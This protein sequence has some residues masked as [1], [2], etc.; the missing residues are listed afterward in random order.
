MVY[1]SNDELRQD[2]SVLSIKFQKK[3]D[4]VYPQHHESKFFLHHPCF[5]IGYFIMCKVYTE[6]GG[7]K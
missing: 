6:K 5:S 2:I 4:Q 7:I 1:V 3:K